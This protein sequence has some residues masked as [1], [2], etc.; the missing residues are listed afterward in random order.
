MLSA[1]YM[2]RLIF[3]VDQPID[4]DVTRTVHCQNV[5]IKLTRTFMKTIFILIV[6]FPGNLKK[7]MKAENSNNNSATTIFAC[8]SFFIQNADFEIR[9]LIRYRSSLQSSAG[10]RECEKNSVCN[11]AKNNLSCTIQRTRHARCWFDHSPDYEYIIRHDTRWHDAK[12]TGLIAVILTWRTRTVCTVCVSLQIH[13]ANDS[14]WTIFLL[15]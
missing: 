11:Y 8:Q 14:R 1:K 15:G 10:L 13:R 3:K 4:L 2:C 9:F 5:R 7:H 6:I 12:P